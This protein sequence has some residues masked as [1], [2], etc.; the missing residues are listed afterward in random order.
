VPAPCPGVPPVK[1]KR[2]RR[3]KPPPPPEVAAAKHIVFLQ[4]NREAASKCRAKKKAYVR[5]L[6]DEE[7]MGRQIYAVLKDEVK[8][9][10]REVLLLRKQI[11]ETRCDEDCEGC[12]EHGPM[13]KDSVTATT[14]IAT[15]RLRNGYQAHISE[16]E[17][18][19]EDDDKEDNISGL[20]SLPSP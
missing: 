3:R 11:M 13:R 12:G 20:A 1:V 10:Q 16:E 6:E 14:S 19:E 5:D 15:D 17:V 9:L 4:R 7:R 8:D 2:R 18:K